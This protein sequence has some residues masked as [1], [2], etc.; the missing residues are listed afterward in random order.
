MLTKG[1]VQ[2]VDQYIYVQTMLEKFHEWTIDSSELFNGTTTLFPEYPVP[3]S[4]IIE[5]LVDNGNPVSDITK[6]ALQR[7]IAGFILVS[8]EQLADFLPSSIF[9]SAVSD[10]LRGQMKHYKLTNLASE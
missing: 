2:Y 9:G 7:I 5:S 3:N 8:R 4:A 1:N 6:L 10:E